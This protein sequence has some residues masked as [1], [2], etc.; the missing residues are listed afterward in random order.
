M[1]YIDNFNSN[2]QPGVEF[3]FVEQE[4]NKGKGAAL[5]RG[6]DE[7]TGDFIIVQDAPVAH[8]LTAGGDG[9]KPA[10]GVD[11]VLVGHQRPS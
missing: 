3:K 4:V 9:M 7:A 2:P 5:H 11:P 1:R 6:F 8:Q 10:E